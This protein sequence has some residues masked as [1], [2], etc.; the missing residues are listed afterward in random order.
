MCVLNRH[1][2]FQIQFSACDVSSSSSSFIGQSNVSYQSHPLDLLSL[3]SEF[4]LF[5]QYFCSHPGP[6]WPNR[7]F[8]LLGT[9]A[10]CLE[11]G[12]WYLE[13]TGQLYPHRSIF[14]QVAD[15]GLSWRYYYGN[16][17]WELNIASVLYHP[18]NLHQREQF[19]RD[20][21]TGNLPSFS[22]LN[23]RSG[24]SALGEGSDDMHPDHD[25]ALGEAFLKRVYE[26]VRASPNW[27]STLLLITFDE[28]GGFYDHVPPPQD[29]VPDPS[30]PVE[31]RPWFTANRLGV[32][33]PM[34][35]VSPWV[36]KGSIVSEPPQSQKPFATSAF[37]HTSIMATTRRLLG[38]REANLT[39]RDG[40]AATFEHII[41][42]SPR[43][44]PTE[45]PAP[46]PPAR[47]VEEEHRLSLNDLQL[48]ILNTHRGLSK[49]NHAHPS[50]QQHVDQ[51][52]NTHF[53]FLKSR[54]AEIKAAKY[55]V[56]M[57]AEPFNG[58]GTNA[59][60][61][62]TDQFLVDFT[63]NR[64]SSLKLRDF[65]GTPYCLTLDKNN[66]VG[67]S[68]CLNAGKSQWLKFGPDGTFRSKDNSLCM[69]VSIPAHSNNNNMGPRRTLS[70][71][72]C[73]SSVYQSFGYYTNSSYVPGGGSDTPQ[74]MWG[75]TMM[76]LQAIRG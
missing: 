29:G 64:V 47:S 7:W 44:A 27:N 37:E 46:P 70:M 30:L 53:N 5:D 63:R 26:S 50:R 40:W 41:E 21:A 76:Y 69:T 56:A 32:R 73:D 9:S 48:F 31:R 43:W 55:T 8:T 10:G 74:V 17:P 42:A 65:F 13:K 6:T 23:P 72:Q 18:E 60:D 28:H 36:K 2:C 3:A 57:V 12:E 11:T 66:S 61:F 4:A 62:V 1:N 35:A 71:K 39:A 68:V 14:D 19:Y 58:E 54:V 75:D 22:W 49:L 20:C 67:L 15:A 34:I 24:M 51:A 33:V 16:T 38:I 45:T 59:P 52:L 25:V